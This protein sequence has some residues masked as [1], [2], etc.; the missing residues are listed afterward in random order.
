MS[1]LS[2][3]IV[4]LIA[5]VV[6]VFA[7]AAIAFFLFFDANDFREDI[8]K[9]VKEATG[10]D[11]VIEGEVDLQLFPWLAVELGHTRLGNAP[12][13]GDEPFAE[14]DR[15]QLSVRLL[16][17]LLRQEVAI[18]TAEV[19]GLIVNIEVNRNGLRNWSDLIESDS[20]SVTESGSETDPEPGGAFEISGLE[21][22]NATISY[23]HAQKGDKYDLTEVNL[24]LGRIVADGGAIPVRGGLR[25][26]VQPAALSGEL[27]LETTVSFDRDAGLISFGSSAL[28]GVVNG[29]AAS[30][31][32]LEFETAGIDVDT[33]GKTTAVQPVHISVLNIDVSAELQPFSYADEIQPNGSIRIDEFSPRELMALLDVVPPETADPD[34]LSVVA[35]EANADFRE[36]HVSLSDVNFKLDDTTFSGGMTVPFESDGRFLIDL[37][38]DAID[39]NRYMAPSEES[40]GA[41]EGDS[42]PVEI[43]AELIKALNVRGDLSV[44]SVLVGDFQLDN[45]V[46]GL[47]SADGRLRINPITSK[48][49]GGSY[50]GDVRLDVSGSA[51]VLSMN[52][53][54]QN[55]DLASLGRAMVE[56]ENI[57][58]SMSGK[59]KLQGRGHDTDEIQKTLSG[60]LSFE[61]KDGTY[62]GTDIWY[63]LRRARALLKSEA[64]PEPVLPAR[65][66]FSSVTATGVVKD[67][68]M[69]NDDLV[70]DLSF[71]QLAG[72]GN[73]DIA[74]GTVNYDLRAKVYDTPEALE[75][76]TQEE[77]N[78]FKKAE[79]PLKV[80]G[81][82]A[83][84]KVRPDVEALLRQQVEDEIKDKLEDKLKDLFKR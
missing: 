48:L 74:A 65:T 29:I 61:L 4:W 71:M 43:P 19:D 49:F 26:D 20:G 17:L 31:T 78:D 53:S 69:R 57:T 21:I 10:R 14:L 23:A 80:T 44:M 22:R 24:S 52:E 32:E 34:A 1:R 13:F 47:N 51:P 77:I 39:M 30:P 16:P 72:R 15:A 79:I 41:G 38:A 70:A 66:N 56:E 76:A 67:G 27:E 18:G 9:A 25:Y 81:S 12:G 42:A 3:I 33:V 64:E 55:V 58:G 35:I 45:V 84:P 82:L 46:L 68:V 11:L 54:L 6:A 83:S 63:E 36:T 40:E 37:S 75:Q 62:E 60:N 73:V 7:M 5:G 59:F 2:K 8:A 50:S 28:R